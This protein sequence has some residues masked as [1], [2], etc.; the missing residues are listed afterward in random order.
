MTL[1]RTR[2]VARV[3]G[4]TVRAEESRTEENIAGQGRAAEWI[5]VEWSGKVEWRAEQSRAEQSRAE[6]STGE[7]SALAACA[8][9]RLRAHSAGRL[10][11]PRMSGTLGCRSNLTISFDQ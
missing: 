1:R 8:F 5:G 4:R 2:E 11:T 9:R 3:P 10:L 6:Q 7:Q